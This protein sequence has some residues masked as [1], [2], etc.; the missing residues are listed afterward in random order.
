MR[1]VSGTLY[2]D[3]LASYPGTATQTIDLEENLL[4]FTRDWDSADYCTVVL[5]RGARL[6]SADSNLQ[7][8]LDISGCTAPANYSILNSIYLAKTAAVTAYGRLE[9]VVDFS[10]IGDALNDE[11]SELEAANAELDGLYERK[12][13]LEDKKDELYDQLQDLD[14]VDDA[15][16]YARINARYQTALSDYQ[17]ANT[18]YQT[19]LTAYNTAYSTYTGHITTEKNKLIAAAKDYLE[20]KQFDD[21]TLELTAV[22]MNMVDPS[23]T[24]WNLLDKVTVKARP[25]F[26]SGGKQFAL[27]GMSIPLDGPEKT[28]YTLGP[29]T[30]PKK[31]RVLTLTKQQNQA[32]AE[33]ADSVEAARSAGQDYTDGVRTTL[34]AQDAQIVARVEDAEGAMAQIVIDVDGIES[35]VSDA[36]GDISILTQTATSLTGRITNA[37]GDISTLTQ[38]ATSLGSRITNAEGDIS[39]LTQTATSLGSRITNAE[40]D[41]S[42]LEQT[43]T[44]LGSRVTNAEGDISSL[45]QTADDIT[46][47]ITDRRGNYTVLTLQSDGLH[48][49]NASGTTT[50]DGDC[51]TAGTVYADYIIGNTIDILSSN[52]STVGSIYARQSSVYDSSVLEFSCNA[53]IATVAPAG[54]AYVYGFLGVELAV[55]NPNLHSVWSGSSFLPNSN[56]NFSLGKSSYKWTDVY[57]TNSTIQTS[58]RQEKQEIS[59]DL[60]AYDA[61]FDALKPCSYQFVENAHGRTHTGLIAQDVEQ[62]LEDCGLS[63]MDFAAF[64]KSLVEEEGQTQYHY[65]LRYGELVALCIDQ[66][67]RLKARV[68]ELEG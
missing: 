64:I 11:A 44:S 27:L 67:Q 12:E 41:I 31:R 50:I 47:Q 9:Q 65:G 1:N 14:P 21:M 28:K 22:D 26:G 46:A 23:K 7:E 37:E 53:G 5:P 48:I 63:D 66:I 57:A 54:N 24:A 13:A 30:V 34:E 2:L 35:R 51:L 43:A 4:D 61:L 45:E 18:A 56:N 39:S 8:Y 10:D 20:D 60:E 52:G 62:A 55:G 25:Y 59:Y 42:S 68:A 16:E 49:G 17:A 6:E 38:T 32:A 15:S 33:L 19:A 58:D 36:E 40:G 29:A 3:Y